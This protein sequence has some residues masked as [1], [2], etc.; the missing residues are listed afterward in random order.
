MTGGGREGDL[1]EGKRRR[2]KE[3]DGKG[4]QKQIKWKTNEVRER[5]GGDDIKENER[6][7]EE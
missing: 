7:E 4:G 6:E 3:A 1:Q 5:R 2:G